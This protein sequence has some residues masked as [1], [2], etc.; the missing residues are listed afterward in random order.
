M[1]NEADDVFM[2]HALRLA[3]LAEREDEVPVGAVLV[4]DGK[5]IAEGWNKSIQ[6]H[7]PTAHAEIQALRMAG[8]STS[9]YR[10]LNSTL[11]VTLEPCLMCA[12]AM[13][14]ARIN[15]LVFGAYDTKA[16]AVVSQEQV[17]DKS[18]LNHKI[19]Y[20]GGMLGE[21]CGAKLLAF[22]KQKRQRCA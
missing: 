11:Y 1:K 13:V 20:Q 7:D 2:E 16:G 14:H 19:A 18:F 3:D 17:F 8:C 12:A 15:R 6:M 21:A 5:V 10:L 22:F 9:N 4:I